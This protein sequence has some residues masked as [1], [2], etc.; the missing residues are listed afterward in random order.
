M[1]VILYKCLHFRQYKKGQTVV[2]SI[3]FKGLIGQTGHY[4][5]GLT[6]LMINPFRLFLITTKGITKD[7]YIL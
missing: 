1:P 6:K 2:I 5:K 7:S 3:V 4:K